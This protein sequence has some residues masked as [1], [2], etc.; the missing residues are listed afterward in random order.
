MVDY[1]DDNMTQLNE[2]DQ[3]L[4]SSVEKALSASA[5]KSKLPSKD[6]VKFWI[7]NEFEYPGLSHL[8]LD[9]LAIPAT[10]VQSEQAFSSAKLMMTDLR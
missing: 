8:A 2:V 7:W 9:Y 4:S 3:Y 10:L 1:G 6:V 5:S